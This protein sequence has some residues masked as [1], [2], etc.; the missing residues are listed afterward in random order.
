[1]I[2]CHFDRIFWTAIP[3]SGS[4]SSWVGWWCVPQECLTED[5][6][7]WDDGYRS[8]DYEWD[9]QQTDRKVP[10]VSYM[11]IHIMCDCLCCLNPKVLFYWHVMVLWVKLVIWDNSLSPF[12]GILSIKLP[13]TSPSVMKCVPSSTQVCCSK[14]RCSLSFHYIQYNTLFPYRICC[15]LFSII[16]YDTGFYV[17]QH[18]TGIWQPYHT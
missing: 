8:E 3:R 14:Q 4:L 15:W 2:Q 9:R 13:F 5:Y 7:G 10:Q 6:W 11:Y 18:N 16:H 1:M 12:K 17:L